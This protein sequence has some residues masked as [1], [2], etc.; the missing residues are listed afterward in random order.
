MRLGRSVLTSVS[1]LDAGT[2]VAAPSAYLLWSG[3]VIPP[4]AIRLMVLALILPVLLTTVDGAA[5]ARRRGQSLSRWIVWVF[6]AALPFL[7]ALGLTYGARLTGALG[8]TPPGPL[9]AGAVPLGGGGVAILLLILCAVVAMFF[10]SGPVA[11]AL[12]GVRRWDLSASAGAGAGTLLVMCVTSLVIWVRNP[13]AAALVVPALHLWMWIVDPDLRLPRSLIVAMLAIGLVPP[14]AVVIYY[15]GALGLGPAGVA[16]NG[17]L[18]VAGGHIGIAVTVEWS[19]LL[20]CLA[21][22]ISIA[23]RAQRLDRPVQT[24]VTVRGPAT[25]AGPG[26]LGGTDSA[27]RAR[28]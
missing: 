9:A 3:K 20:A 21:S 8:I 10:A 25:Y 7:L 11:R 26:S 13:M 15:A 1:A 18:L 6:A 2:A 27:L 17:L 4:W 19:L 28:R 23:V 12:A 22:V 16:W 14:V 24:P 5:R